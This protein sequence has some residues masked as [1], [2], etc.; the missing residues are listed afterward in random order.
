MSNQ[1]PEQR[2]EEIVNHFFSTPLTIEEHTLAVQIAKE[3]AYEPESKALALG[4]W[5]E[6]VNQFEQDLHTRLSQADTP[7]QRAALRFAS[8]LLQ[9]V[10]SEAAKNI[11]NN[12]QE[13]L[14]FLEQGLEHA[15]NF[16][17]QG[18]TAGVRKLVL[19]LYVN[20]G[21]TLGAAPFN[22]AERQLKTHQRG[23]EHA[24][25]FLTQ[26][27]TA[28]EMRE[29]MLVLYN[30]ISSTLGNSGQQAIQHLPALGLLSWISLSNIAQ[31]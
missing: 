11:F 7:S 27:E 21:F 29:P 6:R 23:L 4:E 5:R 10:A 31:I 14:T 19:T 12:L 13:R 8:L 2:A 17:I 3:I 26:G 18:E 20:A 1:T 9:Y 16:L 28:A 30:G 22:D 24:E 25:N 15:E